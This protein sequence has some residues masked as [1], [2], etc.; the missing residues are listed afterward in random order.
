[1]LQYQDLTATC[2]VR[3]SAGAA[4]HRQTA[5]TLRAHRVIAALPQQRA[6]DRGKC[7]GGSCQAGDAICQYL[8]VQDNWLQDVTATAAQV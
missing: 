5:D 1:M 6:L 3:V 8:Y 4:N 7:S 2:G